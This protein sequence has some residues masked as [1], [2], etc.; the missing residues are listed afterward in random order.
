M[1]EL[2]RKASAREPS[3]SP[4]AAAVLHV[5][6]RLELCKRMSRGK[7]LSQ[8]MVHV[9]RELRCCV[10]HQLAEQG[11]GLAPLQQPRR[12]AGV[13][14]DKRSTFL[15]ISLFSG[16]A[17]C[18]I[19]S[20]L[21]EFVTA[22]SRQFEMGHQASC[23]GSRLHTQ[24]HHLNNAKMSRTMPCCGRAP[25]GRHRPVPPSAALL[26]HRPHFPNLDFLN[27]RRASSAQASTSG[28]PPAVIPRH[29]A[30]RQGCHAALGLTE[31]RPS[32]HR[33][34]GCPSDLC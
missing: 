8:E 15:Q 18:G 20:R 19:V 28:Q 23:L 31:G 13:V 21:P 33:P 14:A 25:P 22:T 26:Q 24:L 27:A 5:R 34:T 30:V 16:S 29:V 9:S 2:E 7:P 32:P 3:R 12:A 6:H 4:L 10:Y 1:A 17:A 11:K